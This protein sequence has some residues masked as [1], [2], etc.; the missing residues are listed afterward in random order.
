MKLGD[1]FQAIVLAAGRG[2]RMGSD[3]PKVLLQVC[4]RP[5]ISYIL[6]ALKKLGIEKPIAVISKTG[7]IVK[8]TLGDAAEYALQEEQ[9][10]SGNAVASAR[11]AAR[12]AKHV[13]IM[14]GDSPLFRI[15]TIRSLMETHLKEGATVTMLSCNLDDPT[16]YG[17]IVRN[18]SGEITGIVEEKLANAEQ[19]AIKEIN[20]GCYAFDGGW[21][22]ENIDLMSK[23]EVGEYCLTE[24]VDI[25]VKQRLKVSAIPA[26]REELIGAN[27]P[28]QL[29]VLE[30]IL[31]ARGLNN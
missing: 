6:D 8:E 31:R 9:L 2:K 4:N 14:C 1:E 7:G 15:E 22:W 29:K 21:L 30:E 27:T 11:D 3:L 18:E 25:A 19:K 13:I 28:E 24:M 26:D 10:G 12:G 16:G 17:R 20:G 23:N 5:M